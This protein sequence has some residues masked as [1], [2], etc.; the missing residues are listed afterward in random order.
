MEQQ[1]CSICKKPV[2]YGYLRCDTCNHVWQLGY[3]T[4]YHNATENIRDQLREIIGIPR[5][6][7]EDE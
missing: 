1:F 6:K 3:E 7:K 4:G 5:P 2:E